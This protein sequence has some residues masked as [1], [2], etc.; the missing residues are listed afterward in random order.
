ME[1]HALRSATMSESDK[2]EFLASL[3]KA[4]EAAAAKNPTLADM[5]TVAKALVAEARTRIAAT[6]MCSP[7]GAHMGIDRRVSIIDADGED[8][9]LIRAEIVR[10]LR[11][12]A[13]DN[14]IRAAAFCYVVDKEIPG[15]PT[16]KFIQVHME[17]VAGKAFTSAVPVDESALTD[18][19]P[20]LDGP[21]AA[22]FGGGAQPP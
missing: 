20:G 19:I 1:S 10:K 5:R 3:R 18:N 4:A 11:G 16:M 17:H 7:L 2:Q 9:N 6:Q 15:G 13:V 14:S 8:S 12:L 22:L 21:A